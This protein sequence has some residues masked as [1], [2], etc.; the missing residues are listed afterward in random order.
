MVLTLSA[1]LAGE[2]AVI[3]RALPAKRQTLLFSATM[4]QG[5]IAMQQHAL[6]QAHCF[7]VGRSVPGLKCDLRDC[8]SLLLLLMCLVL[9]NVAPLAVWRSAASTASIDDM[10]QGAQASR[11]AYDQ[12]AICVLVDVEGQTCCMLTLLQRR[13]MKACRLPSSSRSSTSSFLL[14]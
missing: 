8:S 4:T 10:A 12:Q 5:L 1:D 9:F 7:Q 2:L 11:M 14:R 3:M 6:P 13:H